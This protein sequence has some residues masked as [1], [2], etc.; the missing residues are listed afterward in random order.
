[1]VAHAG[2]TVLIVLLIL[3][4]NEMSFTNLKHDLRESKIGWW[5]PLLCLQIWM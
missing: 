1:M 3:K 4:T 5:K 2:S